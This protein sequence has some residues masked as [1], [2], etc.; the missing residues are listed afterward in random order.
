[1]AAAS[2]SVAIPAHLRSAHADLWTGERPDRV[3]LVLFCRQPERGNR[4]SDDV[5]PPGVEALFVVEHLHDD[6]SVFV[7]VADVCH[8]P[9]RRAAGTSDVGVDD[10]FKLVMG[11]LVNT[12]HFGPHDDRHASR[13]YRGST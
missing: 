11:G 8:E 10:L 13:A 5:R 12:V 7:R 3:Y 2:S 4:G 1:M 9:R 6:E